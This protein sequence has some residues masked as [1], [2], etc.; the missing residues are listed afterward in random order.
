MN[1][2]TPFPWSDPPPTERAETEF[3]SIFRHA[4]VAA[5]RCDAQGVIVARNTAFEALDPD[6]SSRKSLRLYDLV[7]PQDRDATESLLCELLDSTRDSFH[8]VGRNKA[9]GPAV[10]NWTAWRLAR[11]ADE[12]VH[13]LVIAETRD[14]ASREETVLQDRRW[15]AV[16]RM[17]GGITHDFNNILT[18]VTL[19]CDLLLSSL[20]ARDRR[21]RYAAEIRSAVVQATV[22]VGQLLAF[23]RPQA[24]R[25]GALCFNQTADGMR[26][27]LN[28][29]VTES[30]VLEFH[31]DPD[32]G[33]VKIDQTQA[34]QILLNL[35]LNARDAMPDGGRIVVETSNCKFQTT[36]GSLPK[37]G[38]TAFPCVLLVIG[39]NGRGMDTKTQQRL[40]E[41]FFTTKSPGKGTG[42]GL[43]QVRDMVTANGGLIHVESKSGS[44]TRVMILLPRESQSGD[45]GFVA[46][47]FI[48]PA[49]SRSDP[50]PSSTPLREHNKKESLL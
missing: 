22:L 14:A 42:L 13:A 35:V 45:V 25:A 5:A 32:L 43:T 44:G 31:L 6:L 33:L 17:A 26:D 11:S 21:R 46:P 37:H 48:E 50:D 12:P 28:R 29:L 47:S 38:T 19:Y 23:A 36:T 24:A 1:T 4:P 49:K 16:G 15:E 34:Q 2:A 18:G 40:F 10:T 41:P 30:V 3:Y 7:S 9:S 27:L 20:D 8:L 39:D